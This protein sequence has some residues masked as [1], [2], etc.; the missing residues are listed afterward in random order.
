MSISA[1]EGIG[2]GTV[3]LAAAALA[4]TLAAGC[5]Q[6]H[7]VRVQEVARQKYVTGDY[8]G[9]VKILQEAKEGQAYQ[10]RDRVAYWMNLGMLLH[11][12][13]KY[14]DSNHLLQQAAKRA[15]ELYTLSIT[16][17]AASLITND[18]VTD[19]QGENF[20]R[21]LIHVVGALNYV[22]AGDLENARVEAVKTN[23]QLKY[24]RT[25]GGEKPPIFSQDAFADWLTGIIYEMQGDANDALISFKSAASTYRDVYGKYFQMQPPPFLGED[26]I[27]AAEELGT[28]F[29]EDIQQA[30]QTFP[31]ADGKTFALMKD[32]GEV[33]LLHACGEAPEKKDFFISCR[34]EPARQ[35]RKAELICDFKAGDTEFERVSSFTAAGDIHKI[36]LPTFEAR[37]HHITGVRMSA[38]GQSTESVAVEPITAIAIKDLTDRMLR[39]FTKTLVRRAA[40][41]LA[42]NGAERVGGATLKD[43]MGMV[44]AANEEADKRSWNTLPSE[45]NVARLWLPPGEHELA[46]DFVDGAGNVVRHSSI[47]ATVAAGKRVI[48]TVPTVD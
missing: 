18:T 22:E 26:I 35:G 25:Q 20:E 38:D 10:P 44:N 14:N 31:D 28:G 40:K 17:E 7:Q 15:D 47:H 46:L 16:S 33:L 30:K 45:F 41:L 9:A 37:K 23:E 21:V 12:A 42:E 1:R 27:R 5:T 4:A 32:H 34:Q 39:T 43:V 48:V 8:D 11:H 2:V 3:S 19:Y 24:F 36:A 6:V 13:G 29:E